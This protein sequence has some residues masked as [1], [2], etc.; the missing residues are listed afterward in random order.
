MVGAAV[1]GTNAS[2]TGRS[3][4]CCCCSSSSALEKRKNDDD[5][6]AGEIT[7]LKLCFPGPTSLRT[8]FA[9]DSKNLKHCPS[10]SAPF[11]ELFSILRNY[12]DSIQGRRR[13]FVSLLYHP[14]ATGN[15]LHTER[16]HLYLQKNVDLVLLT[17][18]SNFVEKVN[19]FT[20]KTESSI[21]TF[22]WVGVSL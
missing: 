6:C 20:T 4:C 9:S 21:S 3:F 19:T 18:C 16:W 7:T 17:N 1:L 13:S 12:C 10:Q 2:R 8:L 15:F 5:S 22:K 11:R 14:D